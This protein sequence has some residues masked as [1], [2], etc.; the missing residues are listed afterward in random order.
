MTSRSAS[1]GTFSRTGSLMT[2]RPAGM[3]TDGLAAKVSRR[4]VP[5]A[6]VGLLGA[7]ASGE[8]GVA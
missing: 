4:M 3:V 5:V 1:C 8:R 6:A 2:C 7:A